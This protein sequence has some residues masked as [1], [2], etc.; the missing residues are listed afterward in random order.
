MTGIYID[1]LS[2]FHLLIIRKFCLLVDFVKGLVAGIRV[3]TRAPIYMY[4]AYVGDIRLSLDLLELLDG[5]TVTLHAIQDVHLFRNFNNARLQSKF[6]ARRSLRLNVF[7]G[8]PT[9]GL[10][11]KD[12]EVHDN[13][14]WIKNC[15]LPA[16][17]VLMRL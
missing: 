5:I 3:Q 12:W 9:M 1:Y 10:N 13:M 4:T 16:D 14:E 6:P 15:A 11:L 8:V 7:K 2:A 17:E